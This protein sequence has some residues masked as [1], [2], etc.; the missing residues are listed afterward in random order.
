MLAMLRT[1]AARGLSRNLPEKT[2]RGVTRQS[3]ELM[4]GFGLSIPV[5]F[6]TPYGWLLWFVVPLSVSR[7]LGS[8]RARR[9]D[10]DR[11]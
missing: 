2:V 10:A 6:A 3:C 11:R 4:A 7:W 9:P 1:M 8:R 5:L